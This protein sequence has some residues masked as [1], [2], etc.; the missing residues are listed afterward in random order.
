MRVLKGRM[1]HKDLLATRVLYLALF[2]GGT[3]LNVGAKHV[4][5]CVVTYHR[6]RDFVFLC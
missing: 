4:R 5:F 2:Y 3:K 1:H 6:L